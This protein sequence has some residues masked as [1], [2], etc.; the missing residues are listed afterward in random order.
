[1]C[2][3]EIQPSTGLTSGVRQGN[4]CFKSTSSLK[5]MFE[6][7]LPVVDPLVPVVPVLHNLLPFKT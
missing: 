5:G 2:N 3:P 1:M 6:Q 4:V 7:Y